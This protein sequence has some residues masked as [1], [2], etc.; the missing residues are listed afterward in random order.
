MDTGADVCVL[1]CEQPGEAVVPQCSTPQLFG[2]GFE[3]RGEFLWPGPGAWAPEEEH[4]FEQGGTSFPSFC[5]GSGTM[6]DDMGIQASSSG[7]LP[8]DEAQAE[9]SSLDLVVQNL[10][11]RLGNYRNRCFANGPFRLWAWVGSFMQGKK[12]WANTAPAVMA[13]LGDTD[14]VNITRLVTMQPLWERFNDMVQDDASHFLQEMVRLSDSKTVI[15]HYHHVDHRQEVHLREA[16]PTHLIFPDNEP[17]DFEQLIAKWANTA[18]GQVL[19]GGGL[20]VAQIGR[21]T[22]HKGEWTKHHKPLEVPSIFNLPVC[23]DGQTTRTE[24]YSLV[25]LLCHTG[26][27]H[28][29]GHFYAIFV[30]RGLYWIAD[31]GAYPR[32]LPQMQENIKQQIVQVWAIPS[33]QLLPVNLKCDFPTTHTSG[34]SEQEAKRK[35]QEGVDFAFANVTNMG[36]EVR[37]WLGGR[38]RTPIFVAETH[39]G[40]A[41]HIKTIQWLSARGLGAMGIPAAESPKGGTYGGIMLVYPPHL[42]LHYI[43]HQVIE[44][45]GWYAVMWS[46]QNANIILVGTYFKCGEGAQGRT[47]SVLWAGLISFVTSINHAC[48]ICGDFNITPGEFMATTMSTVMQVQVLAT[49]E[50]TCTSGNELDWALVTN[51]ISADLHLQVSWEVPF[52]PHAQLLFHLDGTLEPIAVNQL[53]RYNPAPHLTAVKQEWSQIEPVERAVQWLDYEDNQVSRHIGKIYSRIERYVMQNLDKPAE[54]RGTRLQFQLKPLSDPSKAW[55]WKKGSMAFWG[56]VEV[57]L[58]Q[59]QHRPWYLLG[60]QQHLAQ[61]SWHIEQH[62]HQ[63][64]NNTLH[65]YKMLFDMIWNQPEP[66]HFAV[67]LQHTKEQRELHQATSFAAETE[68][69]REWLAKAT[70][71]GHRD[72][73]RCLKK[74]EQPFLR[75]FQQYPRKERMEKRVHQWGEIWGI[76]GS[77]HKVKTLDAMIDKAREHATSMQPLTEKQIWHTIKQLSNKAPG[78][79]GIGFDFL[80]ALPFAAMKDL[81][82]MYHQIEAE[83]IVPNQWL[84]ALIAMLP[85]TAEIERPIALVATLYR[86]WCRLRNHYTKEWQSQLPEEFPW[87]RAIPGTECLQVALRRAFVT[88]HS[89]ALNK[90]V[91]SVLLDMSNF[92]DRINLQKLAERWISSNY[93]ATHAAFAMQIYLG[94]RILE[95]EGEASQPMWTEN[96]ILAGD[97][98]APLAAK[99]YLQK[100]MK[101]FC[102]KFPFLH[103]DLWIDDLSFDVV[104][105]DVENAVRIALQA[106]NYIKELLEEDNLKLSVKKTGFVTSNVQAKRMLQRQLPSDGPKVHDVMKDLGVDCTAGRLRRLQTIKG[107]RQKAHK[108]TKK[109]HTLKIPQ[110]AVRLRIYKGSIQAGI[111]WGHQALGLAPQN[112]QRLRTTM[113]RQMG[114]QR[115]GNVDIV[116]D[117]Q[118]RHRDPDY[119]AFASQIKIYRQCFGNWPEHLHRDLDKA[120]R[121]TKERLSKAK[122][123][124]QVVK[125]PV[126][127]LICYLQDRGWDTTHYDRWTKPGANGEEDFE[128]NMHSSWHYI[129]EELNRAQIR[130]R[131]TKIQ[132]RHMLQ[133][134]QN[135]LDWV[136][137]K[138]LASRANPRTKLALQTWHQG[139]IFTKMAEGN[140][141]GH[142]TCPHCNQPATAVHVLWLCKQTNKN[143]TPLEP[144]DQKELEQGLNLEFWAQGLLQTPVV[145]ISTGGAAIQAWGSMTELDAI[146]L[147]SHHQTMTIGI[148]TTSADA[149]VRHYIVTIVHHTIFAGEMFRMGAISTVLPGR[150]TQ[151]RAWYYGLRMIAHYVD[152]TVPT[153][154]HVLSVKAWQAW[155]SGR[156]HEHFYDLAGLVTWDQR[157]RVRALCVTKAQLLVMPNTGLSLRTRYKDANKAAQE[158]AI[159]R[160]PLTQERELREQDRKYNRIAPLA[161]QRIKYLLDTADHFLREH[162]TTGK[163]NRQ[164]NREVKKALFQEIL[165]TEVEGGHQWKQKG[166][167]QQC[168]QCQCRIHQHMTIQQLK[169]IKDEKC[170][171]AQS[172]PVKGGAASEETKQAYIQRLIDQPHAQGHHLQVQTNYLVCGKCGLRTLKNSAR[173]KIEQLN[174]SPCWNGRWEAPATWTGHPTHLLQRRGNRVWCEVCGAHALS[175]DGTWKPSKQLNKPCKKAECQ[176]QLPLTFKVKTTEQPES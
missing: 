72:L 77:E 94:T 55:L 32:A 135:P 100:A 7:L 68:Q 82:Q 30:Y 160:R 137:W 114:L 23:Y 146:Q 25:G 21:Y 52:R 6:D 27:G 29:S 92:Y 126:A 58:Q 148:A 123:P 63:E 9:Q 149:R 18:E 80:K 79:D 163:E 107:R 136:P 165:T 15:R 89:Q 64:G 105:R 131:I 38:S 142:V 167:G 102:K 98:Q 124:W 57:R 130:E 65:N 8:G 74:D 168:Q 122:H 62:W 53:T 128:L 28:K 158:V 54:G 50:E 75:P 144:D 51:Q 47:N 110:R 120:W 134:V 42:H 17:P 49:G 39:L 10:Q 154:A 44:G 172:L 14:V 76:R 108:K 26:D 45:C 109:L 59:I 157:Q 60:Y 36:Q 159:S 101:A 132:Q 106:Y 71:K 90:T 61:L 139:A 73:F 46:F 22:H 67:L 85:K 70:L 171:L 31:D 103:V 95:A 133:D 86:L 169:N 87:E 3:E 91:I 147:T 173:A 16:F 69:Y 78:L 145:R 5:G 117:M 41:D 99:I 121:V 19:A 143:C 56:Q 116:Y 37:Q 88:E 93:P 150:Q 162:K 156:H 33:K 164:K 155:V 176:Q 66:E 111:S 43:Q 104:D 152:L 118:Q 127:A 138:R 40:E 48:I 175:S 125:G 2:S 11:A 97:P 83:A 35:C 13:M 115:T 96:C 151:A 140:E 34:T 119:E 20:R 24:Q 129:R 4:S 174:N 113:A 12:L 81:A 153:R 84:V 141:Q 170:E 112:R 161:A 166:N 1:R